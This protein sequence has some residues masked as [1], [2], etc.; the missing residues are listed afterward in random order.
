MGS[1]YTAK[2]IFQRPRFDGMLFN[3]VLGLKLLFDFFGPT[4]SAH[5]P[6]FF[7]CLLLLDFDCRCRHLS[8]VVI[9]PPLDETADIAAILLCSHQTV[10]PILYR[11]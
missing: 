3:G 11:V 7:M 9:L 10:R 1:L 4:F 8:Q 2:S 6:K 5:L